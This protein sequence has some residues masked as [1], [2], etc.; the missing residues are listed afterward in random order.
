VAEGRSTY[1]RTYCRK[2]KHGALS[3]CLGGNVITRILLK[4]SSKLNLIVASIAFTTCT[5]FAVVT[6]S[7]LVKHSMREHSQP[8]IAIR[9]VFSASNGVQRDKVGLLLWNL[10]RVEEHYGI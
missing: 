7:M 3:P 6:N 4:P 1:V 9:P 10:L 5:I 2:N 8:A